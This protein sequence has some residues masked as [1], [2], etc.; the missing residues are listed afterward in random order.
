MNKRILTL[1]CTSVLSLGLTVA[2][3]MASADPL[4]PI[5][6]EIYTYGPFDELRI[7]TPAIK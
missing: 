7:I 6:V 2:P 4:T 1:L 3:A 5:E